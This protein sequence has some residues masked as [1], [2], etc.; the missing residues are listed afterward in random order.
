[1]KNY[2]IGKVNV[3][4]F[5]RFEMTHVTDIFLSHDWG[6]DHYNHKRV[7]F[8]NKQLQQIGYKTWFDGECMAGDI[9]EKMSCGIEQAK[10]VIV[11]IT[12]QYHEQVNGDNANDNCKLEFGHA[13]RQKNKNIVAVVMEPCMTDTKNWRGSLGMHLGGKIYIDMSGDLKDRK[14]FHQKMESLQKELQHMGIHPL[15]GIFIF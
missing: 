7:A 10:G 12:K 15:P 3:Y 8:I 14:Y 11:F 5:Y 1:M 6:K 9:D 13:T 4:Y 2:H